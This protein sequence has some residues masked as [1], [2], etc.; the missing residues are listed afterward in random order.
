LLSSAYSKIDLPE[1]LL[2]PSINGL[3][4]IITLL[5]CHRTTELINLM[6]NPKTYDRIVKR[7]EIYGV[8]EKR[9]TE[10]IEKYRKGIMDLEQII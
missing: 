4:E 3:N 6:T 2:T 7:L 10:D 9:L 5:T 1:E 8:N